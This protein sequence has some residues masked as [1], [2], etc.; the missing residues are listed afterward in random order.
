MVSAELDE[1]MELSD[2]ILVM[3]EGHIAGILDA[4][5]ATKEQVGVLMT[6]GRE[7]N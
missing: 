7:C 4:S 5:D 1:I 3:S 2:R 6:G